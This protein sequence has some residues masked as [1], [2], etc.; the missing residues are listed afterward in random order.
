VVLFEEDHLNLEV[1]GHQGYH[2]EHQ[3]D[4]TE[5]AHDPVEDRVSVGHLTILESSF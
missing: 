3:R 5:D 1:V 4:D 2:C